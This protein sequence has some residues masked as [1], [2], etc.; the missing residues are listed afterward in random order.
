MTVTPGQPDTAGVEEVP[1]PDVDDGALLIRG[2][3]V[4]VCGT[5]REIAAGSYGEAPPDQSKLIIG[6]E[7][8]G[9]VLEAP[10]GSRFEP[11][12]LVVGIVRRPDP[13]PC[14]ACAAGEWDMCR[15]DGFAERGIV[16]SHGYGSE[17]WRVEPEF[18]VPIPSHLGD[19]GVL[20]EPASVLAKGWDQVDR[21]SQRAFFLPGR[22]LITGAGPIGLMAC[23]L[24][25]Q[26]GYEVHVIDLASGG[27]K[28]DLVEELGAHYHAGDAAE[29]DVE[30]D[31]IIEC[32]GLGE[33]GRS[34]AS[35]LASGGIM[36]LTGIMDPKHRL[37]VDS[38]AMNRAMVLNNQVLFGTVNAGR[39]HWQ[40]AVGSL[41]AADR[42][43][44]HG[45]ITRRVSLTDWSDALE[46]QPDDIKVVIDLTA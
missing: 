16:R 11:G 26:R 25:V 38:T 35:R 42:E 19:L 20:L 24:G 32:T 17:R 41:A 14:P 3:S 29:L 36:C 4:G 33:V 44:L 28:R 46:R 22:A 15:N 30:F 8:L 37:D 21:I 6:H 10:A 34:A 23:L 9:E 5:D 18:A 1:E 43:W 12:D 13:A 31:A 40:Q 39:R 2:R 7:G 27:P 45:L